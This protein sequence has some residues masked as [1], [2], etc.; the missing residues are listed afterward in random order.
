MHMPRRTTLLSTLTIAVTLLA[1]GC[2]GSEDEP[3][4]DKKKP[5]ASAATLDSVWD[6]PGGQ[7][8]WFTDD[9]VI[10]SGD[11]TVRAVGLEDGAEQWTTQMPDSLTICATSPEV[12]DDG[13]A[14]LL[15]GVKGGGDYGDLCETAAAIDTST[16]EVKWTE[17]FDNPA[18]SSQFTD[19]V[20]V[21]DDALVAVSCVTARFSLDD[22]AEL[23]PLFE[24]DEEYVD[25]R[26]CSNHQAV[27][28]GGTVIT[29]APGKG[30]EG[31]DLVAY[32]GDTGEELW[33]RRADRSDQPY[34][35]VNL[36]PLV[37]DILEEGVSAIRKVDDE[38]ELGAELGRQYEGYSGGRLGI[39]KV[40][41]DMLVVGG[42]GDGPRS[43]TV[44]DIANGEEAASREL[45]EGERLVGLYDGGILT[46]RP[47]ADDPYLS[48]EL[49]YSELT[50]LDQVSSLGTAKWKPGVRSYDVANDLLI[51]SDPR[52]V[53]VV[54]IPGEDERKPVDLP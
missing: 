19:G 8:A 1:S 45:G 24:M 37:L 14:G 31:V 51:V 23:E 53:K 9:A 27:T 25:D 52:F 32:D 2:S 44:Y 35:I 40:L 38:G 42:I 7:V 3:S 43:L 33:R 30:D 41:D 13:L 49:L 47:A 39:A 12:N 17:Q 50:D 5:A 46:E 11:Q 28:A 20:S 48:S 18:D 21:G 22:G 29:K 16:G 34:Q 10:I 54:S 26:D 6:V 4:P 15:L 36:E